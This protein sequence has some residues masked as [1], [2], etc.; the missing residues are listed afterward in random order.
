MQCDVAAAAAHATS[1]TQCCAALLLSTCTDEPEESATEDEEASSVG[2]SRQN[3]TADFAT[4]DDETAAKWV[5]AAL[6]G[7]SVW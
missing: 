5:V 4:L 6:Q 2:T 1:S 3:S 7:D